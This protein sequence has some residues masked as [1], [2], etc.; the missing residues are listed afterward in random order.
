MIPVRALD[1][2]IVG[3]GGDFTLVLGDG[4]EPI[5]YHGVWR[6]VTAAFDAKV[7]PQEEVEKTY[8]EFM[9]ASESLSLESVTSYL[10]Y[11]SRPV[12]ER[13]E[14]LYPVYVHTGYASIRGSDEPVPL[15]AVM[16]A[17][18]DFGPLHE[19]P[20]PQPARPERAR[21]PVSKPIETKHRRR[22]YQSMANLAPAAAATKPWEAGTSWIGQSRRAG[23][24]SGQRAGLRRRVVGRRLDH[25]LQLG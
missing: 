16:L 10:A 3:G 15:R 5:G 24:Q 11:V 18:T 2:P 23:R 4:S 17:A 9:K 6:P 1:Q 12:S 25:R 19:F 8:V 22:T 7:I 13:Q 14:F 21:P 20:D